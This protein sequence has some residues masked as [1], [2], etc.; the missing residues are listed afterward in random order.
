[1]K[2]RKFEFKNDNGELLAGRL[3][4]PEGRARAWAVF[5]HCFTC[6]KDSR[7]ATRVSRR[8]CARGFAVLRF[9][10]TGLGSSEG[11]FANTTFSSNVA[12]LVAA[13]RAVGSEHGPVA[14]LVGHS[15]GGAAALMAA[16]FL[17][18]VRAVATIGT[19]SDPDHLRGLLGDREDEIRERGCAE[20]DVAGLR[21]PIRREFLDDLESVALTDRVRDLGRAVLFTHS[22]VD[23]VVDVDHARRL[24]E[25]ARHPKSFVSLDDADHLLSRRSD[26]EYAGEVIAAWASR[27]LPAVAEPEAATEHP[28]DIHDVPAGEIV[29][30]DRGSGYTNDIFAARHRLVADEPE[31]V[32]RDA[33]PNPYEL[34]LAALGACTSMTLR[35]YAERKKWPLERVSVRLRHRHGHAE[36]CADCEQES[37]GIEIFEREVTLEGP[38]DEAQRARLMEMADRCPVHRSLKASKAIPTRL[39]G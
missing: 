37:G 1:M 36:D 35:M 25:A 33:G 38:L 20:V 7:A 23:A 29:V 12:D 3:E 11:D 13:A 19:P 9:D 22:P 17:S 2:S 30:A 39:V 16:G 34:L 32:G 8:L 31:P 24:Y 6:S 28:V 5:A 10:F 4:L 21:F 15:Q 14:L 18:E 26:A 27:Y